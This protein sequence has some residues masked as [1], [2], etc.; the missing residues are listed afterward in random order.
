[1]GKFVKRREWPNALKRKLKPH[2]ELPNEKIRW[3]QKL[4]KKHRLTASGLVH[5]INTEAQN[6]P[7]ISL[8]SSLIMCQK[9]QFSNRYLSIGDLRSN[10]LSSKHGHFKS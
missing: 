4:K 2:F 5:L 10:T 9:I 8:D 7:P 1:M 3:K 6:F